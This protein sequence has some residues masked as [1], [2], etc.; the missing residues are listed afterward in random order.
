METCISCPTPFMPQ[1]AELFLKWQLVR[2]I[3]MGKLQLKPACKRRENPE[4]DAF[5]DCICEADRNKQDLCGRDPKAERYC[6]LRVTLPPERIMDNP[7]YLFSS[8]ENGRQHPLK[9][10]LRRNGNSDSKQSFVRLNSDQLGVLEKKHYSVD[11][12]TERRNHYLDLAGIE[13]YT[14]RFE[15]T[16]AEEP[17]QDSRA[18]GH[19]RRSYPETCGPVESS[20]KPIP[21]LRSVRSRSKSVGYSGATTNPSKL[22]GHHPTTWCHPSHQ[23]PLLHISSKRMR[24]KARDTASPSRS[25]HD[26][27]VQRHEHHHHH[28]HQPCV[29]GKSS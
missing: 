16:C 11:E 5:E 2:G 29:R 14:S 17:P 10:A 22:H 20:G 27:D 1:M 12:N 7:K 28:H 23:Q 26:R 13:N 6:A 3:N 24:A 19:H 4:G 21:F 8:P 18:R 15:E 9:D 25:N